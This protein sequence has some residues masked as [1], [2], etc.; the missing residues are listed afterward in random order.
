[1]RRC[2]GHAQASE[3]WRRHYLDVRGLRAGPAGE[4][5]QFVMPTRHP[6]RNAPSPCGYKQMPGG[7][8]EVSARNTNL[9]NGCTRMALK[10]IEQYEVH[11]RMMTHDGGTEKGSSP[12]PGHQASIP[13]GL[14]DHVLGKGRDEGD[15]GISSSFQNALLWT[16]EVHIY[17]L[18]C[19]CSREAHRAGIST[20]L[21][22]RHPGE[23]L[24]FRERQ[25]GCKV[26]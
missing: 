17:Q 6:S 7:Q 14:P 16:R 9:G 21:P 1:M 19:S 15:K 2:Q 22:T 5:G 25:D 18:T 23:K 10:V 3:G 24:S 20:P 26:I 13:T 12:S 4:N 8:A 11:L